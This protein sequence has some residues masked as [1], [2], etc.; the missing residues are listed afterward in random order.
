MPDFNDE[1]AAIRSRTLGYATDPEFHKR[2]FGLTRE[3][4]NLRAQQMRAFGTLLSSVTATLA[5]WRI[6]DGQLCV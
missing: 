1:I 4:I 5:G 2:W 3:S 6:L